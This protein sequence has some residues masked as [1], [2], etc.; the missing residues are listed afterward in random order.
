MVMYFSEL[1]DTHTAN[2]DDWIVMI[3]RW[4]S[5]GASRESGGMFRAFSIQIPLVHPSLMAISFDLLSIFWLCSRNPCRPTFRAES[6]L[7]F[8]QV[9]R[10]TEV[11]GK[12]AKGMEERSPCAQL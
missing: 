6:W 5:Y 2:V 3:S 9:A 8:F 1:I 11:F 12:G 4:K 10:V 7:R